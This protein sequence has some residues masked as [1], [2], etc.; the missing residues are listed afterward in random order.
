MYKRQEKHGALPY[1]HTDFIFAAL[2]EELGLIFSL[3]TI[4]AFVL[5]TI[6]G[7]GIALHARDFFGKVFAS[8]LTMIVVVPGL[9]N[10]G[11][12]TGSLPVTGLPL[13]FLS[14]GGSSLLF[15]L[16]S[17]GMLMGVHRQA[18]FVDATVMP[19]TKEQK[20]ALKL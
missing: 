3:I 18:V 2:G 10:M 16:A 12:V 8:G 14:Y 9:L 17:I 15:T 20:F 11:V 1:A 5:L 19:R 13:P 4:T 7:L 6:A